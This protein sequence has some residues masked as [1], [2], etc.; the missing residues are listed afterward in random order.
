MK[1]C[2]VEHRIIREANIMLQDIEEH[3]RFCLSI[4]IQLRLGHGGV[5]MARRANVAL[6]TIGT[7]RG[8]ERPSGAASQHQ[9]GTVHKIEW[10][11][12]M[13]SDDTCEFGD[14]KRAPKKT[15]RH[16]RTEASSLNTRV[17][18]EGY[19]R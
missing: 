16:D 10:C 8:A 19:I 14:R 2:C 5:I 9:R 1:G 7:E 11:R 6:E 18:E 12:N 15:R 13:A 17:F 4:V 3:T